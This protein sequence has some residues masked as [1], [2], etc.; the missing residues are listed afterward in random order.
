MSA[1]LPLYAVVL[2]VPSAVTISVEAQ[3]EREACMKALNRFLANP[4]LFKRQEL[5]QPTIL[6]C[7]RLS[8]GEDPA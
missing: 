4:R 7:E 2:N 1:P 3:T 6:T 5:E 8:S